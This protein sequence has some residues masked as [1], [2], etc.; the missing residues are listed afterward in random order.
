MTERNE[1]IKI[2]ET[3]DIK[4]NKKLWLFWVILIVVLVVWWQIAF[5]IALSML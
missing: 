1:T 4:I 5:F 2:E 3:E